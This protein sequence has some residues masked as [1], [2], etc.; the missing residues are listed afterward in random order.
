MKYF[1]FKKIETAGACW[2]IHL[3]LTFLLAICL[4]AYDGIEHTFPILIGYMLFGWIIPFTLWRFVKQITSQPANSVRSAINI[5]G[6]WIVATALG[7][8][9]F[10]LSLFLPSSLIDQIK[11]NGEIISNSDPR[12]SKE[13]LNFRFE[14]GGM[15]L[16]FAIVGYFVFRSVRKRTKDN[17]LQKPESEQ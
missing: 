9:I 15:G 3:I 4:A 16:L 2:G 5:Y 8:F 12:F 1:D 17:Q 14:F 7:V 11:V 6:P 13:I 10:L